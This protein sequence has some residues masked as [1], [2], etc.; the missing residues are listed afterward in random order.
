MCLDEQFVWEFGLY[1]IIFY[2]VGSLG[3]IAFLELKDRIRW[4]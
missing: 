1:F 2:I 3:L 4:R